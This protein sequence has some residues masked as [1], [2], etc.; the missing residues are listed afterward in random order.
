MYLFKE[1]LLV[2]FITLV[3]YGILNLLFFSKGSEE[4][5]KEQKKKKN[6]IFKEPE[7]VVEKEPPLS[8]PLPT[9]EV[10]YWLYDSPR[11]ILS[12]YKSIVHNNLWVNESFHSCFYHFLIFIFENKFAIIDKNTDVLNM[13]IKNKDAAIN[14]SQAFQ[15]YD[16]TDLLRAIFFEITNKISSFNKEY[17]Q[18]LAIAIIIVA[19]RKTLQLEAFSKDIDVLLKKY[20][21]QEDILDIVLLIEN[22]DKRFDF[23]NQEFD[24]AFKKV[25][26]TSFTVTNNKLPSK[27]STK[28]PEKQL[29]YLS[30]MHFTDLLFY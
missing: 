14:N 25:K 12:A 8:Q 3:L 19:L 20:Q 13:S 7:V 11:E 2:F 21:F 23:I 15:V 24:D 22:K 16:V 10:R 5:P 27:I 28:L 1:L 18:K 30:S 17:A 9:E 4:K 6:S 26:T 29:M